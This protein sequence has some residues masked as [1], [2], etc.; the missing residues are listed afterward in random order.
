MASIPYWCEGDTEDCKGYKELL[1]TMLAEYGEGATL[2][3]MVAEG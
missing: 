3:E 2:E 1:N